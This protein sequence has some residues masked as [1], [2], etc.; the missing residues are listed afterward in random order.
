MEGEP[1]GPELVPLLEF[2]V[3]LVLPL[4]SELVDDFALEL[5]LGLLSLLG[6]VVEGDHLDVLG[7]PG[8]SIAGSQG[9]AL[10]D[11]GLDFLNGRQEHFINSINKEHPSHR[12]VEHVVDV[13][14]PPR[15]GR[16]CSRVRGCLR[17][18]ALGTVGTLPADSVLRCWDLAAREVLQLARGVEHRTIG[19][20]LG[21]LGY[22]GLSQGHMLWILGTRWLPLGDRLLISSF[23]GN[24]NFRL[25]L[26]NLNFVLLRC[27]SISMKADT[28][29]NRPFSCCLTD[30][31]SFSLDK[32]LW[33]L[34][35]WL[36]GLRRDHR[37][38]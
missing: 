6:H 33:W 21:W 20:L 11:G 28:S 10:G 29:L 36:N 18:T 8:A 34:D 12:L 22:G 37:L 9:R 19:K 13:E 32:V 26:S 4:Q 3:V 30:L 17:S 2:V 16:S 24:Q 7:R 38:I 23:L 1:D 14:V 35:S 25:N 31:A 5:F 15:G 27:P